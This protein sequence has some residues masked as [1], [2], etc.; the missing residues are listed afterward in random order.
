MHS[1]SRQATVDERNWNSKLEND[2]KTE[3]RHDV[4]EKGRNGTARLDRLLEFSLLLSDSRS[5]IASVATIGS[6][7]REGD[8][9]GAGILFVEKR[10]LAQA[11]QV[12]PRSSLGDVTKVWCGVVSRDGDIRWHGAVDEERVIKDFVKRGSL[13]YRLCETM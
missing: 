12:C 13:A 9:C 7:G 11:C 1:L 3:R 8:G 10:L 6:R 2:I 5:A 4:P